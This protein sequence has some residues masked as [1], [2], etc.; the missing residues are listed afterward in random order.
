MF[1]KKFSSYPVNWQAAL[2]TLGTLLV[3]EALTLVVYS[4]FFTER[5]LLDAT[6]TAIIVILVTFPVSRLVFGQAAKL[7]RLA[8]ELQRASQ[9]DDL[10]GLANRREFVTRVNGCIRRAQASTGAGALLF[11]DADHFKQ[12]NDTFGHLTG[13]AVLVALGDVIRGNVRQA[14]I[15]ARIG[16]EEFAV[17]LPN[18]DLV[19][20]YEVAERVR[21]STREITGHMELHDVGVSVSIGIAC[22]RPGQEIEEVMRAADHGLYAAKNGGRDRVVQGTAALE[23]A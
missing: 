13:D 19:T 21:L 23:A 1:L 9:T 16:G 3:A 22:H 14:D 20:A 8:E 7:K 18:T 2:V 4:L 12:I 15:A 10:T 6:L 17:F 5:I 11:V